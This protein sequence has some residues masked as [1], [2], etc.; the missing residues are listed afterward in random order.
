MSV[1]RLSIEQLRAELSYDPETGVLTRLRTGKPAYLEQRAGGFVVEVRG[2]KLS[3]RAAALGLWLGRYPG[4]HEFH[5]KDGYKADDLRAAAFQ[6]RFT[7]TGERV[8]YDCGGVVEARRQ[9]FSGSAGARCDA[10]FKVVSSKYI[11]TSA[12][13]RYGLTDAEYLAMLHS[14]GR[15][16][17]ICR[18]LVSS[19]R[20]NKLAVDHCHTTGAVRGLLCTPCNVSLGQFRDDPALLLRAA[21]Y[22][23]GK[24]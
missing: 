6:R 17:K 18:R 8:C 13:K 2:Y 9:K 14:Q 10:C 12:L 4:K 16:C 20:Y 19:E 5:R 24:L 3:A 1:P 23:L 7:D 21:K 15:A 22:L 11:R